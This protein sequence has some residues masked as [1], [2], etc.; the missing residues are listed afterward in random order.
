MYAVRPN[1][2]LGFH[3][4]DESVANKLVN[5]P[6]QILTSN[7]PYDWLGHGMY[8]WENNDQRALKWAKEKQKRG[9]IKNPTIVGAV[10][11][12]GHCCDFLDSRFINL[13]KSYYEL[14]LETYH[15]LGIGLPKNK[16]LKDDNN[17][18][19]IIRELDCA[20]I[21]F[22]HSQIQQAI[23]DQKYKSNLKPFD[24][25]RGVFTE[26]SPIFPGAGINE[27]NH[28]QICIRNS[29]CIKG[30]FKPR[31]ERDVTS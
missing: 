10:I 17:K 22:M 29:D 14:M 23:D 7:K 6:N 11:F 19:K 24:S 20:V 8:F 1:L 27:K 2:V 28:I 9:E 4:C 16:D 5:A 13:I 25:V 12:L 15:M 21:E 18:D 3:G 30:F 31:K 26:G